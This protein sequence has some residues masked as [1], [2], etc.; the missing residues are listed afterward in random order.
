[1]VERET[2]KIQPFVTQDSAIA[3][4][5]AVEKIAD[6]T[7]NQFKN[8]AATE[9]AAVPPKKIKKGVDDK[10]IAGILVQ[11]NYLKL[12]VSLVGSYVDFF[13]F[14]SRLE[15]MPYH[16]DVISIRM[17]RQE[18]VPERMTVNP[19]TVN[20]FSSQPTSSIKRSVNAASKKEAVLNS[21]IELAVYL[22]NK[23]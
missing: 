6:E 19:E 16:L 4:V 3:F 21:T 22:A 2:Q 8:E 1:M 9:V 10:G 14:L 5:E 7:G 13:R 17:N 11:R 15:N 18:A 12:R 23:K 20:P